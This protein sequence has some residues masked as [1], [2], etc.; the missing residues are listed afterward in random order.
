MRRRVRGRGDRAELLL[1]TRTP[2]RND[3]RWWQA[4]IVAAIA[5]P[6]LVISNFR[7]TLVHQ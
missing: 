1:V 6:E 2:H 4:Q 5:D 7:I 3:D